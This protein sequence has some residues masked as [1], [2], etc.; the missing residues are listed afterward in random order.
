MERAVQNGRQLA[1]KVSANSGKY[2]LLLRHVPR[3]IGI[4]T[5]Q[6]T[7]SLVQLW[8]NFLVLQLLLR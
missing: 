6:S 4:I 1:L 2:T 7:V 5:M 8:G 3:I